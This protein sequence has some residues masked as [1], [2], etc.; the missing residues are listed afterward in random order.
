MYNFKMK[1]QA[2]VSS[3]GEGIRFYGKK[4][5]RF[6]KIQSGSFSEYFC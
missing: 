6:G 1:M 4:K 3:T 2:C 5:S